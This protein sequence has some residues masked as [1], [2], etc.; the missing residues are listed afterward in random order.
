MFSP[1]SFMRSENGGIFIAEVQNP[2]VFT[3]MVVMIQKFNLMDQKLVDKRWIAV[4]NFESQKLRHQ[5]WS[6][7]KTRPLKI[8]IFSN[9][10]LFEVC[11]LPDASPVG[12]NSNFASMLCKYTWIV[13]ENKAVSPKAYNCIGFELSDRGLKLQEGPQRVESSKSG[14]NFSCLLQ[15]DLWQSFTSWLK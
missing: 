10:E 6:I 7:E 2:K 14:Q 12:P 5:V 3:K 11:P 15:I 9:N 8:L 13:L 1:N 4:D